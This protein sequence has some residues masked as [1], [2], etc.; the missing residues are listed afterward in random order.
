VNFGTGFTSTA[1][2]QLN[3]GAWVKQT[4]TAL[5]LTDG[6]GNEAASVFST[7]KV[8]VAKFTTSFSFQLSAGSTAADGFTF[9]LQGT[10]ATALGASGGGLGYGTDGTNPGNTIGKS[11]ALKFDLYNNKGEGADSIGVFTNG[12]SPTV[13][14]IT[15]SGGSNDLTGSGID[16]HSGHAFN[17]SIAYDGKVLTVT[18]TDATTNASIS[19]AYIVDIV[20]AVG[21]NLGYA[22]FT[23]GT[24]G[25][26]ATQSILNWTY[27]P[28]A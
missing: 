19:R 26:T 3:G 9:T 24:G 8:D 27:S 6:G 16:L 15:P 23:A 17:V 13:G 22:G 2:L 1:G 4:G 21:G 25:Q 7:S 10:G 14:G 11:V 5:Q 12:A 20:S 28:T 18:I